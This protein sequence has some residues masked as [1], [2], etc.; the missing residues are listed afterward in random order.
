MRN[1]LIMGR[2]RYGP[3]ARAQKGTHDYISSAI[4]RLEKYKETGNDEL[5]VDVANLCLVEFV[6]GAHPKKHFASIDDSEHA[7]KKDLYQ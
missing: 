2:F 5:L 1:R 7:T 6:T 4:K 3:L